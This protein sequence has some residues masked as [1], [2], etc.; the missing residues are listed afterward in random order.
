MDSCA[1]SSLDGMNW[2]QNWLNQK[3]VPLSS[4][5][6]RFRFGPHKAVRSLGIFLVCAAIAVTNT[7]GKL[8]ERRIDVE[9]DIA[10]DPDPCLIYRKSLS[11]MGEYWISARGNCRFRRLARFNFC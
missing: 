2:V 3:E 6:K 4:S 9:V 8:E 11:M 7:Q 5:S 1:P 10:R